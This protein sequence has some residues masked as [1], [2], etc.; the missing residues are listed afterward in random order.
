MLIF[1]ATA[2]AAAMIFASVAALPDPPNEHYNLDTHFYEPE[3]V[4]RTDVAVVGGG[5]VGTYATIQLKDMGKKVLLIESKARL[6]GHTETETDPLTGNP[7]DIGV[8]LYH[9]EPIVYEW[10]ERFNLS[11]DQI[12]FSG[13]EG[14]VS[15]NVDFRTGKILDGIPAANQTAV[16]A[17]I[18]RYTAVLHKYPQLEGGFYLPDPVPEDLY[19]PFGQ[20]VE[21]CSALFPWVS[22]QP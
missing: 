11:T 3:C 13:P 5:G 2:A 16:A 15:R 7:V 22:S 10:F 18:Q 19:M 8:K 12:S 6:G 1:T 17:A 20:F 14:A 21:K 4:I 9:D